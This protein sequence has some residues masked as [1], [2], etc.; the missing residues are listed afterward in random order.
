VQRPANDVER[1]SASI[2]SSVFRAYALSTRGL[3]TF[4]TSA[5]L[6][7]SRVGRTVHRRARPT[8]QVVVVL[9]GDLHVRRAGVTRTVGP[10]SALLESSHAWDERW[11][12]P[13]SLV[14]IE[15]EVAPD[16]ERR[17]EVT[18]LGRHEAAFFQSIARELREV[19]SGGDATLLATRLRGGLR[20]LGLPTWEADPRAEPPP[21]GTQ[22][23]LDAYMSVVSHLERQPM[24]CDLEASLG[25]SARQLRRQLED[26]ERWLWMGATGFRAT[27][28]LQRCLA[29]AHFLSCNELSV[30]TV[31]RS[32]GYSSTEALALALK[33]EGLPGPRELRQRIQK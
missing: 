23:I 4:E 10:G 18:Q 14:A 6:P 31:A 20:A 27:L 33:Q 8:E 9:E 11:E 3:P 22:R 1:I 15:W 24:W 5:A 13:L 32:L 16:A 30:S 7:S 19:E 29:A 28:R 17:R 25:L 26:R 12:G 21:E 2:R